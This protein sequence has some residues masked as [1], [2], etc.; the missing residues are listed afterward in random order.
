MGYA[1]KGV[2]VEE[3]GAPE[4]VVNQGGEWFFEEFTHSAGV[5]S[6]GLDD[7]LPAPPHEEEKKSILDIFRR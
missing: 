6:L 4:G 2:P 5:S 3:P 1:L 7:K